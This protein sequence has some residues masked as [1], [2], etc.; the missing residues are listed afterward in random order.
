MRYYFIDN[1]IYFQNQK[2]PPR[3]VELF[4]IEFN[5]GD[6]FG[7]DFDGNE[8]QIPEEDIIVEEDEPEYNFIIRS[9]IIHSHFKCKA[10]DLTS[11]LEL[12]KKEA[13]KYSKDYTIGL[14]KSDLQNHIDEILNYLYK[15][16]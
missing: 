12:A 16:E 13:I 8:Y 9:N 5:N 7:Y 1:E 6:A 2:Q 10:K 3:K 11:A 14:N 4:N 15:G